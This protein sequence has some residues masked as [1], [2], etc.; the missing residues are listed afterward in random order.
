MELG[1]EEMLLDLAGVVDEDVPFIFSALTDE[2]GVWLD[3]PFVFSC[4]ASTWNLEIRFTRLAVS[5]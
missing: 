4:S 2:D 1:A 3:T 5:A